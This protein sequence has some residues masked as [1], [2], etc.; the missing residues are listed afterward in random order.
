MWWVVPAGV[1]DEC[2]SSTLPRWTRGVFSA[3]VRSLRRG[4]GGGGVP[5][6]VRGLRGP[7]AHRA[8]AGLH[9]LRAGLANIIRACMGNMRK[10]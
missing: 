1:E 9:D 5:A 4:G 10:P 3:R 2:R 7:V 8:V 6:F